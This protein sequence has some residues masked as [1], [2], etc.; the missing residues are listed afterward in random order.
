[1]HEGILLILPVQTEDRWDISMIPVDVIL[2]LI[3]ATKMQKDTQKLWP[4]CHSGFCPFRFWFSL[5]ALNSHAR[6]CNYFKEAM[7]PSFEFLTL[8]CLYTQDATLLNFTAAIFAER[9]K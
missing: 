8:Y 7:G 1:V 3:P 9:E 2:S 5:L 4:D 6:R